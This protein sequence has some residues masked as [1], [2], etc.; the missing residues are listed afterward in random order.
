MWGWWTRPRPKAWAPLGAAQTLLVVAGKVPV[1]ESGI[2]YAVGRASAIGLAPGAPVVMVADG[3]DA[4]LADEMPAARLAELIGTTV[5]WQPPR[6]L[7][8]LAARQRIAQAEV[9][10]VCDAVAML[11]WH[12]TNAF[13]GVDG[14]PS[15]PTGLPG[16][17]RTL[18]SGRSI[19]P[20]IDPVAIVLCESADGLRCLLGRS[21]KY[22]RGMYTCISGFVEHAEQV[23]AAAAR[24]LVEETGV[25]CG[26]VRLVASQPWP[27][28][29]GGTCE[30]ML[31]CAARA[32]DGCEEINVSGGSTDGSGE[33]EDARWFTREEVLQMVELQPGAGG[34]V[35]PSFAIAHQ[36]IT[37]WA[38]REPE[39]PTFEA[40]HEVVSSML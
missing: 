2:L 40:P 12:R 22:P 27:C 34:A 26:P 21:V 14:T 8:T 23:E 29:R 24:E 28:G 19:Y 16:R 10:A 1:G 36:M 5:D 6:S 9:T 33:L 7:L 13:S 25:R 32:A 37:K 30:L 31:A 39:W 15:M 17:R 4:M 20:R 3:V 18:S 35:P 38:R 11:G